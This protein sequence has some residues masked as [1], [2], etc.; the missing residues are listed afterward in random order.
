MK[1][2]STTLG[3][4]PVVSVI[5]SKKGMKNTAQ[6]SEPKSQKKESLNS[7]NKISELPAETPLIY[8]VGL[9]F[10]SGQRKSKISVLI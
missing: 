5:S 3:T 7:S 2:I 1:S 4:P 9:D 8:T 6:K 10:V